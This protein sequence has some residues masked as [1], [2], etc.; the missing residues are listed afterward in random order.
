SLKRLLAV[1]TVLSVWTCQQDF[2]WDN[3]NS[4]AL[5]QITLD[6]VTAREWFESNR[7]DELIV[8]Q[9]GILMEVRPDW[10]TAK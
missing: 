3:S 6:P 7:P 4:S 5:R 1:F 10:N 9:R 2:N 8:A